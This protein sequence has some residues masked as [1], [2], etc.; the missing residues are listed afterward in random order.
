MG[1]VAESQ[2]IWD[3]P[4][5]LL[6]ANRSESSQIIPEAADQETKS[7]NVCN[8]CNLTHSLKICCFIC[9][10]YDTRTVIKAILPY[11]VT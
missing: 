5:H 9:L 6:R 11:N 7:G 1:C 8:G 4:R 10:F 3:Y 2:L